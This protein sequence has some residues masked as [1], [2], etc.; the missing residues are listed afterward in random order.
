MRLNKYKHVLQFLVSFILLV[1]LFQLID[2]N[3]ARELIK[4]VSFGYVGVVYGVYLFDRAFMAWKWNFLLNILSIRFRFI[5]AFK[6][7]Y[8]SNFL[9]FSIPFGVGPDLIRFWK[10]KEYGLAGE[11]AMSSIVVERFL[12]LV[13]TGLMVLLSISLFLLYVTD[14]HLKLRFVFILSTLASGLGVIL[15]LVFHDRLRD[16]MLHISRLERLFDR[17]KLG[18]YYRAFSRYKYHKLTLV[19]F[20]V[21]SFFEQLMPV[22]AVFY[23]AKALGISLTFYQTL[24]FVPLSILVERLPISYLGIGV[25]EGSYVLLLR[26]MGVAPTNAFLLSIFMFILDILSMLPAA[27]WSVVDS[28]D[29]SRRQV[30]EKEKESELERVN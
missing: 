12:G 17:I 20:T 16:R 24:A 27:V 26:F 10:I 3:Q 21:L 25:R 13:A 2:L 5:D 19:Q 14:A 18:N 1:V 8:I 7:Y 29:K 23:A 28:L 4:N 9:G 6:V 11:D 22:L 15:F 30:P